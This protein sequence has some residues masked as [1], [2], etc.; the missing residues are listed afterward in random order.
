MQKKV[1]F[2]LYLW[3]LYHIFNILNMSSQYLV[4]LCAV[5]I[6]YLVIFKKL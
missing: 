1:S 5:D 4:W 2:E 6:Y 3:H